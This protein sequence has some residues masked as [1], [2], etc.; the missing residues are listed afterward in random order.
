VPKRDEKLGNARVKRLLV[1]IGACFVANMALFILG[2][3]DIF[4]GWPLY[5]IP[6]FEIA[7]LYDLARAMSLRVEGKANE[8]AVTPN[9]FG[10]ALIVLGTLITISIYTYAG[11]LLLKSRSSTGKAPHDSSPEEK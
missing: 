7:W 8:F 4:D 11:H 2:I 10:W 1:L 9:A 5:Q 6:L 3:Y